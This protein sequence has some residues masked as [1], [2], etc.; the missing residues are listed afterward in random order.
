MPV[1]E[2]IRFY[3]ATSTRLAQ[4]FFWGEFRRSVDASKCGP[5]PSGIYHVHLRKWMYN[6]DS[7]TLGRYLAS[8]T[9]RRQA[10]RCFQQLQI[11]RSDPGSRHYMPCDDYECGFPFSE[12]SRVRALVREL[13]KGRLLV[14][15][16]LKCFAPFPFT[17]VEFNRD[18][19]NFHSAEADGIELP[20]AWIRRS[21]K[22]IP[23]EEDV[24]EG[25]GNRNVMHSDSE[26]TNFLQPL[27]IDA[28]EQRFADL[29][30]KP[31]LPDRSEPQ[32]YQGAKPIPAAQPNLSGLGT[33]HG[34]SGVADRVP[35]V[36][37][38]M[39]GELTPLPDVP[40][41]APIPFS[42]DGFFSAIAVVANNLSLSVRYVS[43][44]SD[45][46]ETKPISATLCFP[47]RSARRR[48][49]KW[50]RIPDGEDGWRPRQVVVAIL[51]REHRNVQV[52]EAERFD[53]K[54]KLSVLLLAKP[55]YSEMSADEIHE[56]LQL[57]SAKGRW[58]AQSNTREYIR[59]SATHQVSN[60]EDMAP[61]I[62]KELEFLLAS[63]GDAADECE[64]F[65][66]DVD[67]NEIPVP[68]PGEA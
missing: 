49:L 66:F 38:T 64:D 51:T 20:R 35:A 22:E 24:V 12:P 27:V 1:N 44:L 18:N 63:T 7:W 37:N 40:R 59:R 45:P 25:A 36:I 65:V 41:Q 54:D 42:L 19:R 31:L 16:L 3:Y 58:I 50:P 28:I 46:L 68:E 13:P 60:A 43:S 21:L 17:G 55:D 4:A 8:E 11:A 52:F 47:A 10:D 14:L 48:S 61:R 62:K 9:M 33:G 34:T 29:R 30:E 5:G 26:P 15:R 57:T 67:Q 6:P 56:V 53:D 39:S 23:D 2:I 32:Q